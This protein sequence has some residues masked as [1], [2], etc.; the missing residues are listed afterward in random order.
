MTICYAESL[1]YF[2]YFLHVPF[3]TK[4]NTKMPKIYP[5]AETA[6]CGIIRIYSTWVDC[7]F[8]GRTAGFGRI[9]IRRSR[10]V[11]GSG[12]IP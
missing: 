3:E 10:E 9:P 1:G 6:L 12:G 2:I 11:T 7:L 8:T 5:S 4:N